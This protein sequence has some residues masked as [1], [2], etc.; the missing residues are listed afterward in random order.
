VPIGQVELHV[1]APFRLE[2]IVCVRG[3]AGST[4]PCQ[5]TQPEP[6]HLV[7]SLED[8]DPGQGVTLYA[9][10]GTRLAAAPALPAPPAGVPEDPGT[11]PLPPAVTAA[12]AALAGAVPATWL[13]RRAGR[14]R[15]ATGGAAE[16]AFGAGLPGDHPDSPGDHPGGPPDP[17][18]PGTERR[19]DPADLGAL[20]TTEF[21]PPAEL[22]PA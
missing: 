21:V 8:L 2:E 1:V 20:A 10:A 17:P 22:T 3:V 7:A 13:V 19:V 18:G 15:V 14:E 16:A 5:A 9:T 6:G 11:G 4:A 12:L